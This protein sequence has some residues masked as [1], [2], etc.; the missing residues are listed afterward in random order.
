[1]LK[2]MPV[3]TA[4]CTNPTINK[5]VQIARTHHQRQLALELKWRTELK[6]HFM[7]L[8]EDMVG[9]VKAEWQ[10][11]EDKTIKAQEPNEQQK[12]EVDVSTSV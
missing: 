6:E 10:V 8:H 9:F 4:S 2:R 1:M 5:V 7:S 3:C 11:M 12:N